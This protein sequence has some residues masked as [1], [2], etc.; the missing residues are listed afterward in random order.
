[1]RGQKLMARI[2]PSLEEIRKLKQKPTAGEETLLHFLAQL[3]DEYTV[4]FQ[5]FLNGSLP[6]FI[7]LHRTNGIL[8][9]E[10]KDW[11]L[12]SYQ[13]TGG[14]WLLTKNNK[15]VRSPLAQVKG[16]KDHIYSYIEGFV[17]DSIVNSYKYNFLTTAVYFHTEN[18]KDA[19]SFCRE[20]NSY[21][22]YI[23]ILGRDSLTVERFCK[24][25]YFKRNIG[26]AFNNHYYQE[27]EYL[28]TPS[29][30]LMELGMDI[31]YSREQKK[32]INSKKEEI[33]I[34]GVA[35]SGKTLVLAKRAVNAHKRTGN[36]VLLLTYNITLRNF[37]RDKLNQVREEFS[38]NMFHIDN[39]HNFML[40]MCNEYGVKCD[41]NDVNIFN[42]VDVQKYDAIFIDEVQDYRKEWQTIIKKYFLSTNGEFVIFG[43]EKQNIYGNGLDGNDVDTVIPHKNWITLRESY[44]LSTTISDLSI[45]YFDSFLKHRYHSMDMNVQQELSFSGYIGN[46]TSQDNIGIADYCEYIYKHIH[47]HRIPYNDVVILGR[48]IDTLRAM[49]KIFRTTYHINITKT[50]EKQETYELLVQKYGLDT[51]ECKDKL[52]KIRRNEKIAFQM[53]RGTI[54]MSTIHSFKGWEG[55]NIFLLMEKPRGTLAEETDQ[56]LIYTGITRS[57]DKLLFLHL[58][59]NRY[60]M[61][62]KHHSDIV[63]TLDA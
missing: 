32:I 21:N 54:K 6:D 18:E 1:M 29:K 3:N 7:L 15:H 8:V 39:Y 24:M 11:D 14:K 61:F 53:N 34:K 20:C 50:F 51:R 49:E 22:R 55:E 38:W 4:Y 5:P 16:Y 62:L 47:E 27:F 33:K 60:Q 28:F 2:I 57:K 58:H 13:I 12:N 30:H 36:R 52:Q 31:N 63:E 19:L 9:I 17:E 44:R 41:V 10:V 26:N 43:D 25:H 23:D 35:G 40:T 46:I 48:H 56:E 37:I 45:R 59:Q 42:G